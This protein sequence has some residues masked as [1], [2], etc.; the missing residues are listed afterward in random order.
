MFNNLI[1][2]FLFNKS[3]AELNFVGS[4]RLEHAKVDEFVGRNEILIV[5]FFK[6]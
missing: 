1:M 5:T 4:L 2:P 3:L 6:M